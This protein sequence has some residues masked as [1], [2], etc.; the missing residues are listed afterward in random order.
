MS[1][2]GLSCSLALNV[3]SVFVFVNF[4]HSK[5][6]TSAL[7]SLAL[8]PNKAPL[9]GSHSTSIKSKRAPNKLGTLFDKK[10]GGGIRTHGTFDRTTVF[11]TAPINRSGTPPGNL[12]LIYFYHNH[13][14]M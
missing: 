12:P 7:R 1:M 3:P 4:V 2:G 6:K 11:K 8:E 9:C 5:Q 14:K 13:L 10:G